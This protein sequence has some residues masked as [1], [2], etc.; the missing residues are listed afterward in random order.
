MLMKNYIYIYMMV[1][2]KFKIVAIYR[3]VIAT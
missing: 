3:T 1:E 2:F